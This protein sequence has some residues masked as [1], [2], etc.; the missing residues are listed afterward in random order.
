MLFKKWAV[1][2]LDV[3]NLSHQQFFLFDPI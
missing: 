3:L 1:M 2:F